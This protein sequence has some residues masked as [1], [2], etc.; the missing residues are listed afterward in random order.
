VV[1]A[2]TSPGL[3]LTDVFVS[4]SNNAARVTREVGI[5]SGGH[6]LVLPLSHPCGVRQKPDEARVFDVGGDMREQRDLLGELPRERLRELRGR[7]RRWQDR[8]I[9]FAAR[10]GAA[11]PPRVQMDPETRKRLEALG[12]LG[13]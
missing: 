1:S 10:R 5:I 7:L 6:K 12:Y 4:N 3:E 11:T 13:K 9:A 2:A 8:A